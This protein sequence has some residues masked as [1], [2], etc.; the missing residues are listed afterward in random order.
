MESLGPLLFTVAV[1][2]VF[3]ALV[4][5]PQKNRMRQVQAFQ[6]GIEPGQRVVTTSGLYGTVTR[7]EAD[8]VDLE[9]APGVELRWVRAGIGKAV[10][11]APVPAGDAD[12]NP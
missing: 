7:V 9:V 10:D 8:T 12:P 1:F 4:V 3:Y 6:A 2:A 5:K 11:E